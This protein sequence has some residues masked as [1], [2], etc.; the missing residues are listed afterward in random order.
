MACT[1]SSCGVVAHLT[2]ASPLQKVANLS[3]QG[4]ASC[5]EDCVDA[6]HQSRVE[7]REAV[8]QELQKGLGATEAYENV[9]CATEDPFLTKESV[10]MLNSKT[11]RKEL[12][13]ECWPRDTMLCLVLLKDVQKAEITPEEPVSGYI[14]ARIRVLQYLN[15]YNS[16]TF[17]CY[18]MYG[19]L[20]NQVPYGSHNY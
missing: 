6:G 18:K 8:V 17:L 14:Q 9:L 11:K 1:N 2:I 7:T 20:P 3:I 12:V 10:R 19:T 5:R 4:E 13:P 16:I 15:S